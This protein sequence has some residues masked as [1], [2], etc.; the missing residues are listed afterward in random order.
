M[1]LELNNLH[2]LIYHKTQPTNQSTKIKFTEIFAVHP[3]FSAYLYLFFPSKLDYFSLCL[4]VCL[5]VSLSLSVSVFHLFFCLYIYIYIYI[6]RERER[7]RGEGI[8]LGSEDS[9]GEKMTVTKRNRLC[10]GNSNL[11]LHISCVWF[12]WV[13]GISTIGGY[14][15]WNPVYTYISSIH[16]LTLCR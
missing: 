2:W 7:E 9:I 13:D 1:D 15:M 14:I 8:R 12:V 3:L 4:S 5:S 6:Y 10:R 16:H 11:D